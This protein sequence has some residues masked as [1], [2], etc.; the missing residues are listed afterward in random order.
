MLYCF[1]PTDDCPDNFF[2]IDRITIKHIPD[3]FRTAFETAGVEVI[4]A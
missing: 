1:D 3:E 4:I 2:G